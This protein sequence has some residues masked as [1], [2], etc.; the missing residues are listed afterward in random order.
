MCV[1]SA[2]GACAAVIGQRRAHALHWQDR[3]TRDRACADRGQHGARIHHAHIHAHNKTLQTMPP[4]R[5]SADR[6]PNTHTHI[7][8]GDKHKE[9]DTHAGKRHVACTMALTARQTGKGGERHDA[10]KQSLCSCACWGSLC[11]RIHMCLVYF[12]TNTNSHTCTHTRPTCRTTQTGAHTVMNTKADADTDA[13][14]HTHRDSNTDKGTDTS[15]AHTHFHLLCQ[16]PLTHHPL[17]PDLSNA[18]ISVANAVMQSTNR[19]AN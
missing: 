19:A 5:H 15:H 16:F 3:R 8:V 7:T 1:L 4:P 9:G 11:T 14:T 6:K 2:G 12:L 17:S 10:R 18:S 13:E